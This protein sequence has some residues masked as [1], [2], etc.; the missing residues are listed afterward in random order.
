MMGRSV[1][2]DGG[3]TKCFQY[4][5]TIIACWL[6]FVIQLCVQCSSWLCVRQRRA[7]LLCQLIYLLQHCNC[8]ILQPVIVAL[9]MLIWCLWSICNIL[10]SFYLSL[11]WH[12]YFTVVDCVC[13]IHMYLCVYA[14]FMLIYSWV[15]LF[16]NNSRVV[17]GYSNLQDATVTARNTAE[18]VLFSNICQVW[19]RYYGG[20]HGVNAP[21]Q[22]GL[23]PPQR[24]FP[25]PRQDGCFLATHS[26][27]VRAASVMTLQ[28]Q[29]I[30]VSSKL[31][32]HFRL[33]LAGLCTTVNIC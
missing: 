20:L 6:H 19:W 12:L 17:N 10:S 15:T 33:L 30:S 26:S 11:T 1:V 2:D 8:W 24:W 28:R 22:F 5:P 4:W 14:Q 32:L 16:N 25:R 3:L 23:P 27:R 29:C 31:Q 13:V 7:V 9:W 18:H 21:L